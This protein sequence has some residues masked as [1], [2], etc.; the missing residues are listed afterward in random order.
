VA[1]DLVKGA[2]KWR[3]PH[4]LFGQEPDTCLN[5]AGPDCAVISKTK[6]KG[7]RQVFVLNEADGKVRFTLPNTTARNLVGGE[8]WCS[9]GRYDIKTGKKKPGPGV[10][11]T[12][13]GAN[14]VGGC[15][16]PVVV[17]G[18]YVTNARRGAFSEVTPQTR[19]R[20]KQHHYAGVRGGC[21][22][23]MVPANGMFYTAQN[24]CAC[25]GAQPGGFLAVGPCDAPPT[26]ADFKK[27]RP[28]EKGPAFGATGPAAGPD[29]WPTYRGNSERSGGC[30]ARLPAQLRQLWKTQCVKPG[31]GLF[32]GAWKARIGVPQ[33]LTAPVI[34]AGR[35][36]VAGLDTGEVI[37]LDPA[38]GKE[39]WRA[40]LGGRIDSPPAYHRGL[41]LAGCR[42]GWVYALRA[43]DGVLAYR[44][45][46]APAERRMVANGSVESAWPAAGAVLVHDG[47]AY[48]TAGR[49]T[50]TEGG[51]ALVAFK[52]GTGE[53]VWARRLGEKLSYLID[54]LAVRRGELAFNHL[55][56][57]LKTG[58]D[59]P[60]AQKFYRQ[61]SM[62]CG[63]WSGGYSKRSGRGFSLGKVCAN[64]MA[65]NGDL[66]IQGPLAVARAKVD[67]PKAPPGAKAKHPDRLKREELT[68]TTKFEPQT[69]WARV[70]ATALTGSTALYAGSVWTYGRTL[71]GSFLWIK[72]AEDGS[73]L[74][75]AVKLEARPAYDAL[76]V[77][78]GRAYLCL[79]DGTLVCF[80]K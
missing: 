2:E 14:V 4:T 11:N 19:G 77:S 65:W 54:A 67:G 21:I 5:F 40:I 43:A 31:E 76:A 18:R 39:K 78:G 69:P 66:V 22:M 32:A 8:L 20:G 10:G 25:V 27:P 58:A 75:K 16:P 55:R 46:I 61:Y 3:V 12:Y 17:G 47:V 62:I 42:N 60:S 53:T 13:A 51:I 72:S 59:L 28:V 9:D 30:G 68:W 38:T 26:E 34:A 74:Q 33:P 24:N 41:L 7:K 63:A 35:L 71:S 64:M 80:G 6:T 36:Y 57:D 37:A 49:S 44:V 45:R 52:P 23:G 70:H 73:S 56:M 29:D 50:R 1:I 48:A 15:I 79:Q